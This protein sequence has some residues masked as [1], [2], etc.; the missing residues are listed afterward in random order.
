MEEQNF[1]LSNGGTSPC[2]YFGG[3]WEQ[4]IKHQSK[5]YLLFIKFTSCRVW[6]YKGE[7]EGRRT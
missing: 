4:G 3:G 7:E 1:R 2:A 5:I 6:K